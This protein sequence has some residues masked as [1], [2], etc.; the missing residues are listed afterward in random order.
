MTRQRLAAETDLRD[1][2]AF[3]LALM[4]T[5]PDPMFVRDLEGRL[6]MCN[7]SYEESLSTRF[8]QVQGRQLIELDTLPRETAERLHAELMTQLDT[9][10][11][12]FSLRQLSFNSGPKDIYQWTVP[13]YGAD[14]KLRGLLGGW[15]EIGK[16]KKQA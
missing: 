7:K 12:S 11:T 2:L 16:C 13:F 9:R 5:M 14:G 8:D 15:S 4:D 10:K 3:Q 1:Q 6:V